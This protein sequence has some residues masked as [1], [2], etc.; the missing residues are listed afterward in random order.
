VG[1]SANQTTTVNPWAPAAAGVRPAIDAMRG[2]TFG[3]GGEVL[4]PEYV[5]PGQLSQDAMSQ[6]MARA[7]NDTLQ[8]G[9]ENV[10]QGVLAGNQ[11]PYLDRMF[12]QASGKV[13]SRLDSQFAQAGRYGGSDHQIAM[14]GALGDLATNLYGGQYQS[15]MNRAMQAAQIAPGI[16]YAGDQRA[17]QVGQMA[18]E[19]A[20]GEREWDYDQSMARL[21]QYMGMMQPLLGAGGTTTTPVSRSPLAGAL[22]GLGAIGGMM[23]KDGLLAKFGPS[24]AGGMGLP[25]FGLLGLGALA[26]AL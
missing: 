11:N 21:G 17:L 1:K 12:E 6:L 26:G 15:D 13:R 3:Q 14:G 8:S 20:R 25:G 7:G 4:R 22:G 16:G 23:G 10:M 9:A 18:D 2:L 24:A 19:L 5:G